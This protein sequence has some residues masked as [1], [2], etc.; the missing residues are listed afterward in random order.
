[1]DQQEYA[2]KR[3]HKSHSPRDDADIG[4][5]IGMLSRLEHPCIVKLHAV[6]V[7]ARFVDMVF[8]HYRGGDLSDAVE[9]HGQIKGNIPM[10]TVQ[11]LT[12][13]MFGGIEWLHQN[14]IVH[15]DIKCDNFLLDRVDLE[16]PK[17]RVY[18]SDFGTAIEVKP[19]QRLDKFCGT[20]CYWAPEI[21][22]R[23]YAF[24]VDVWAAGV[25]TYILMAQHLPFA[26]KEE[27]CE[28]LGAAALV[29]ASCLGF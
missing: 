27:I 8:D 11:N 13:Q 9:R 20:P 28:I 24:K 1:M 19:G 4:H 25:T 10:A 26:S 2:V 6:Y 18:L 5:E 16:H 14:K 12:W 29:Q 21:Y 23:S 7:N 17:C 3:I 22:R 15:R